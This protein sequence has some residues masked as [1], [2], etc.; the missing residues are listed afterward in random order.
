MD[1]AADMVWCGVVRATGV[2]YAVR[3]RYG[4]SHGVH[5]TIRSSLIIQRAAAQGLINEY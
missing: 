5:V 4:S 3:R 2:L 1:F